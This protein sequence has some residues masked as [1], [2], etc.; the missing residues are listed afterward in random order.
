ME[1]LKLE[2][3]Q[4]LTIQSLAGERERVAQRAQETINGINAAIERYAKE[5]ADGQE[6]PFEFSQRPGDGFYLVQVK[7][8][9]KNDETGGP[10]LGD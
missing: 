1:D 2:S 10:S 6:G 9:T 3:W 4:A 5:W 8:E 7:K